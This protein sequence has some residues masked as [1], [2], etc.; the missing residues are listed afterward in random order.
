LDLKRNDNELY[1]SATDFGLK[2]GSGK[3]LVL[4]RS[5][6]ALTYDKFSTAYTIGS[7]ITASYDIYTIGYSAQNLTLSQGS[8]RSLQVSP[9]SINATFDGYTFGAS[10]TAFTYTDGTNTAGIAETGLSLSRGDNSLFIKPASAGLDIGA[11]KHVYLS[12]SS[13]DVKYSNYEAAFSESKSLSFTDGTHSFALS[14]TGLSMS[15]GTK[16]IKLVD[17]AGSP[18]IELVN[19]ADKFA[20][21]QTGFE[22]K[23]G[24]KRYAVNQTE[25]IRVDIDAQRYVQVMNDGVEFVQGDYQFILGGSTNYVELTDGSRSVALTQDEKILVTDGVYK[26][27]LSKN[28]TVE[29]TD[30][31]R[32]LELLKDDHY[33]T[34]KQDVYTFGIRGAAGSKPGI[35][36]SNSENTFF[37]EGESSSNVSAGVTNAQFGTL[38]VSVNSTKDVKAK[39]TSP[40]GSVYGFDVTNGKLKLINGTDNPPVPQGLTGAPTIPA[41]DGPTHNTNSIS[42]EAGGSIKGTVS[43]Y[44]DSR[45]KHFLMNAAVAGNTPVCIKGAMAMDV[46]PGQFNLDIGTEQQ[47]IEVY[48]TCSGFGGGGWL[49]IHNTN[50]NLGVFVGWKA[51]ASVEIGSSVLGARLNAA[52]SAELGVKA[53]LVLDPFKIKSVGIWVDL[54]AGIWVDYWYPTGSGSFTIAEAS[55]KGTLNAEFNDK[56]HISGSLDGRITVLEIITASFSMSFDTTI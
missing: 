39:L 11:S 5:S 14:N 20:L 22:V 52:A 7:P 8:N 49:G 10:P 13:L 12:K 42:S 53:S 9:T 4:T 35:D 43:I 17:N 16:S 21:S 29:F 6:I 18:G 56:T 24:G 1:V 3:S 55:L 50:V 40:T 38:S 46:S 34:Y 36:F 54:Y 32:T 45:N 28:L 27:S 31:V 37:V 30:G 25:F 47:R 15:D 19:G 44:Y 51:S 23:Y 2:M 33:L 41:Q 48:P 26:G